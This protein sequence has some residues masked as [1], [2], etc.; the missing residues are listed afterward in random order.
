MIPFG[1]TLLLSMSRS[2]NKNNNKNE[3]EKSDLKNILD[4]II[5]DNDGKLKI[6]ILY[7][8]LLN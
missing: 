6:D 1:Y 8:R 2:C 5:F 4:E 7:T 3:F